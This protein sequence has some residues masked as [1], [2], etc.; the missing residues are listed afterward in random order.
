MN[1][2]QAAGAAKNIGGKIQQ[3][4]GKL[5]GS[6]QQ[7]ADGLKHQIAGS[8]QETLGDLKAVVKKVKNGK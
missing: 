5:V 7:Q 8:M 1:K 4:V 2:D 3:E 6:K